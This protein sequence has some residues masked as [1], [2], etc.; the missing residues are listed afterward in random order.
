MATGKNSI[1]QNTGD[2]DIIKVGHTES[3]HFGTNSKAQ[4]KTK[5]NPRDLEISTSS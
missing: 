3:E 5:S 1:N 2:A 4:P